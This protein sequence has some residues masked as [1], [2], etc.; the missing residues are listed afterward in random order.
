MVMAV[1][2]FQLLHGHPQPACR[3]PHIDARLHQPGRRGV[4]QGVTNHVIAQTSI[5]YDPFPSCPDL[6]GKRLAIV[7]A[8]N[9]EL[10]LLPLIQEPGRLQFGRARQV[11]LPPADKV[12][13]SRLAIF[14]GGRRFLVDRSKAP[15]P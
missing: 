15:L 2:G 6:T 9:D 4:T 12:G 3:F 10:Y 14:A 13:R 8:V 5:L 11:D 1:I 7:R